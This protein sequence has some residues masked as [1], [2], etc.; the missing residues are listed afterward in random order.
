MEVQGGEIRKYF[1]LDIPEI[2][3]VFP[4]WQLKADLDDEHVQIDL[5]D[6]DDPEPLTIYS[7]GGSM[8]EVL[9]IIDS[10]ESK[11]VWDQQE[12]IPTW[13]RVLCRRVWYTQKYYEGLS[14]N[15]IFVEV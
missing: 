13:Y 3:R 14:D 9:E 4:M 5:H 15:E 7:I 8:F 2:T 6:Y 11:G 1:R 10:H 12:T